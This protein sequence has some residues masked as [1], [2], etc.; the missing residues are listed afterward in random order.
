MKT[1]PKGKAKVPAKRVIA[2]IEKKMRKAPP[3]ATF[4]GKKMPQ[5]KPNKT[6]NGREMLSKGMQKVGNGY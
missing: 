6:M 1:N 3:K 4:P 2:T 5:R